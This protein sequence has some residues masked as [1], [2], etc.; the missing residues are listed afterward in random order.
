MSVKILTTNFKQLEDYE[1][2]HIFKSYQLVRKGTTTDPIS[3]KFVIK[4]A[5]VKYLPEKYSKI[6][7]EVPIDALVFL[8]KIQEQFKND[9]EVNEFLKDNTMSLKLDNDLKN[10]TKDLKPRQYLDIAIEFGGVW[11]INKINYASW[12]MLDYRASKPVET[13]YFEE[14]DLELIN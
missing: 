10:K 9:I 5:R 3:F 7:V 2:F 8:K 1:L 14:A 12:K 13:N 6:T 11:T 4:G